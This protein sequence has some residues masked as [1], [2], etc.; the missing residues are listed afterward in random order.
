MRQARNSRARLDEVLIHRRRREVITELGEA[1]YELV[2]R[3]EFIELLNHPE[4]TEI[5]AE[6]A[7]LDSQMANAADATG[8]AADYDDPSS[9]GF[10]LDQMFSFASEFVSDAVS[11]SEWKPP[12]AGYESEFD[13]DLDDDAHRAAR[14]ASGD[15]PA[16]SRPA[17]RPPMRVWRP[18][19]ADPAETADADASAS[20]DDKLGA[21]DGTLGQSE[22]QSEA[23]PD[24]GPGDEAISDETN[25]AERA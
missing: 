20:A 2:A 18:T 23:R 12:A 8:V 17:Q 13:G 7:E 21:G 3:G 6:I 14:A 9:P 22:G 1:V 4:I 11:S 15:R 25:S 24:P 16:P 10:S 5:A 19:M